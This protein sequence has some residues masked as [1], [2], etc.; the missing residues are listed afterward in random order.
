MRRIPK[1][2]IT[3]RELRRLLKR[4][5][6]EQG[7]RRDWAIDHGITPQSVS[8]FLTRTQGA[9]LQIPEALGYKPQVIYIPLE[10]KDISRTPSRKRIQ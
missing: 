9:G 8:A 3:E 10:E 7:S 4:A 2:A 5:A 1:S 6:E